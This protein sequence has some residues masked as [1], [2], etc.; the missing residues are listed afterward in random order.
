M[1]GTQ[2]AWAEDLGTVRAV[3]A[4][5]LAKMKQEGVISSE[6]GGRYRVLDEE[7]LEQLLKE[8]E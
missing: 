3:L 6:P 1:E 7:A 5:E 4:R 8:S 2:E